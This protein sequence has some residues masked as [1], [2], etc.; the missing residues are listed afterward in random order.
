V[1]DDIMQWLQ[2][3][4]IVAILVLLMIRPSRVV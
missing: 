1:T 3:V 4:L 2:L